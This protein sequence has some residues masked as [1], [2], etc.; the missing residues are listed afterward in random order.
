MDARL[1][2]VEGRVGLRDDA[3]DEPLGHP[4]L[5]DVV[6]EIEDGQRGEGVGVEVD[7]V[8]GVEPVGDDVLG[9][10]AHLELDHALEID[11]GAW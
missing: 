11:V 6:V 10:A 7:A 3:P 9:V 1:R 2:A 4:H 8:P 5:D